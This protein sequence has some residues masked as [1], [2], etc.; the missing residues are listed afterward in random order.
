MTLTNSKGSKL[1]ITKKAS[2]KLYYV[3][4]RRLPEPEFAALALLIEEDEEPDPKPKKAKAKYRIDINSE[5]HRKLAHK[6]E[7]V[8]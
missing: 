1:V 5:A 3:V 2:E 6:A 8:K 7:G 4:M